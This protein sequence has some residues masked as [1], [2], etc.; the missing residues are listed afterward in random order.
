M[1]Q[2]PTPSRLRSITCKHAVIT[3]GGDTI[4]LAGVSASDLM[5]AN[6]AEV[7]TII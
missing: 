7:V 5:P 1:L 2:R 3:W 4:T 6:I